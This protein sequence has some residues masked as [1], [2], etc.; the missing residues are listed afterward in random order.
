M[1]LGRLPLYRLS[2][3]RTPGARNRGRTCDIRL[4]KPLLCQLSYPGMAGPSGRDRTGD[5]LP[6]KQARYQAALH[7]EKGGASAWDRT[8]NLPIIGRVL[9]RLSYRGMAGAREGIQTPDLPADNRAH[10]VCYATR[11]LLVGCG[12]RIRTCD[13]RDMSP[14]RTASPPARDHGVQ[15]AGVEPATP[16]SSIR[17]STI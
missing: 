2:Y 11:A 6:P 5:L 14:A 9:Y 10:W 12:R 1:Q 17:C 13:L 3:A 8:T 15:G 4:T 7:S 16:G